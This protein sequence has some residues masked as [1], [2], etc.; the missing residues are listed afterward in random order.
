MSSS[1]TVSG[2]EKELPSEVEWLEED[3]YYVPFN[4]LTLAK[5]K[6]DSKEY[7]WSNP[8]HL[9]RIEGS[10]LGQGFSVSDME[11]LYSD[12]E[13]NG[14]L[15][16][17]NCRWILDKG[18]LKIEIIA[19][20]RRYRCI[21]RHLKKGGKVY[22]RKHKTSM[23][24]KEVFAKVPC[25][26]CDASEKQAL[27]LSISNEVRS[28]PWGEGALAI[29]IKMLRRQHGCTDEEILEITKKSSQWLREMDKIIELDD[30]TFSYLMDS[31]INR[32]LALKLAKID[33]EDARKDWLH[34][35]Y[36]DAVETHDVE[37]SK[38]D[39]SLE[40]AEQKEEFAE[41]ELAEKERGGDEEEI[42]S[43]KERLEKSQEVTQEKR[44]HRTDT[45]KPQAKTKNLRNAVR[46]SGR[47]G[48]TTALR[49]GKI[50]KQLEAINA[51]IAADGKDESGEVVCNLACLTVVAACYKA[52]LGGEEDI[53]ATLRSC[54]CVR[55]SEE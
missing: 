15:T 25:R 49:P 34:A 19:G 5:T 18:E 40:K 7:Q 48:P 8:R 28:V 6:T 16:P 41:A 44:R 14:L 42:E 20:E 54:E 47:K 30:M 39:K 43:A 11:E 9:G 27:S 32:A 35:A 23:S 17:F 2:K 38:A 52:I 45:A 33:D 22:S 51:L 50:E 31:K 1:I 21:D 55:A 37:V 36:D 26:I 12:I 10:L 53:L 24:A 46:K 13:V 29:L 3:L 4:M